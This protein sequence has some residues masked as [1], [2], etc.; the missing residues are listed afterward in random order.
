MAFTEEQLREA[1]RKAYA[2]GDTAAAEELFREA[3]KLTGSSAAAIATPAAPAVPTPDGMV[4]DG[5]RA[6]PVYKEDLLGA[7]AVPGAA[8]IPAAPG[9]E[10]APAA[11]PLEDAGLLESIFGTPQE[12]SRGFQV[13]AQGSGRGVADFVG[14]PG[15]FST[16]VTNLALAGVDNLAEFVMGDSAPDA[17]DYR[18]PPSGL[19][20]DAIANTASDAAEAVGVDIIDPAEMTPQERFAYAANRFGTAGLVTGGGLAMRA[21]Q[22]AETAARARASGVPTTVGQNVELAVTSPYREGVGRTLLGD[23]AAGMGAGVGVEAVDQG[24][25][26]EAWYKPALSAVAA[27]FG[28]AGGAGAAKLTAD[29]VPA[30][31]TGIT[32]RRVDYSLPPN[33]DGTGTISRRVANEAARLVQETATNLPKARQSLADNL[34]TFSPGAPKPSPFTMTEDPGLRGLERGYRASGD[35]AL[36]GRMEAQEQGAMDYATERLLS[37]LDEDANQAGALDTIRAR[38]GELRTAREE[39]ALPILREAEASGVTVDAKPVADMLD[40]AM[41]GPKRPEV[42]RALKAARES[43]N[44]PGGD[45]IDTSVKG[46][47]E[48]R[49]AISDLIEGRSESN[50]GKFAQSELIGAKKALDEAIVAAEPRFGEYLTEFKD[51]SRPLDVFEG[52]LAKGLLEHETDVR[53]TAARILSPSRYGTEKDRADVMAMIGDSP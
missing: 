25:S 5:N 11:P 16:G 17:L 6:R 53:N 2:A 12:I 45:Q 4:V 39:A 46:L 29:G 34:A 35:P 40:A 49:K 41:I 26:D 3:Q 19:G 15:D 8:A 42:L 18:F 7:P 48:S 27:L 32:G 33:A 47:Y 23:T 31:A 10:S 22:A 43:L 51:K 37:I 38:P 30:I 9:Y 20:S 52:P 24:V 21:P 28:G 14:L 50:T 36:V 13:G 1:A 44:V